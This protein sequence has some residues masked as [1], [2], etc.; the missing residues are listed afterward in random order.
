MALK[1]QGGKAQSTKQYD[2]VQDELN[3]ITV[4]CRKL[5]S[6]L[7]TLEELRK[8]IPSGSRTQRSLQN[9]RLE[10]LRGRLADIAG[11]ATQE[12]TQ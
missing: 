4:S 3:A 9:L 2:H 12:S 7:H 6:E 10:E 1:F 11:T 5:V 8:S